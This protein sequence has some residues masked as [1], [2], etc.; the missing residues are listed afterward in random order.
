MKTKI[1]KPDFAVWFDPREITIVANPR[2]QDNPGFLPH[3]MKALREDIQKYGLKQP[4]E[5]YLKNDVPI[6]IAGERRL[7][8]ILALLEAEADCYDRGTRT[9]RSAEEV[10]G[11]VPCTLTEIKDD[12]D[13]ARAAVMENLLHEHLTDY[14][15][16]LQCA[17]LQ[18]AGHTRAEQA[19]VFDK[20]E[21]WVSQSHSLLAGHPMILDAMRDGT[22]G[23]T[24]ALKF[25]DYPQDKVEVILQK[26]INYNRMAA[27]EKESEIDKELETIYEAIDAQDEALEAA[28]EKGD[29]EEVALL[30]RKLAEKEKEAEILSKKA[31]K[32]KQAGVSKKKPKPSIS[33]I[34]QAAQEEDAANGAN[35]HVPVKVVRRLTDHLIELLES[36]EPLIN[37]ND[38]TEY[39]RR[40]VR[41]LVDAFNWFLARNNLKSPLEAL[42]SDDEAIAA[43]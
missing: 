10:Y 31:K 38:D 32:V 17:T 27:E 18:E 41:I 29:R 28:H 1:P 11:E 15:I 26:A 40:E 42:N 21:A 13:R 12:K 20:S 30:R 7:R 9:T 34:Q 23:R 33:D 3:N 2:Q 25:L 8:S 37:P 43:K 22:L 6:L 24:Q 16:L 39:S 36:G 35:H 19:K 5:I 14:E 4:V